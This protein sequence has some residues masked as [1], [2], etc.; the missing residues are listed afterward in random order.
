MPIQVQRHLKGPFCHFALEIH[1][2]SFFNFGL[3]NPYENMLHLKRV[4]WIGKKGKG[5]SFA[6]LLGE[7]T[8]VG[9]YFIGFH[10]NLGAIGV[11]KALMRSITSD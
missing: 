8:Q 6:C 7:K 10:F 9:F 5:K 4:H 11:T 3:G 1:G 2:D